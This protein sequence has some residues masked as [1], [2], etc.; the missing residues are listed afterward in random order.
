M[1]SW[2]FSFISKEG[3]EIKEEYFNGRRA[4]SPKVVKIM[5]VYSRH[6]RQGANGD[7]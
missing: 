7:G 5:R 2:L 3:V 4:K 1:V 6:Y